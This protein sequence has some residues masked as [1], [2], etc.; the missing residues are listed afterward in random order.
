MYTAW[1]PTEPHCRVQL[2]HYLGPGAHAYGVECVSH[3]S[4]L[5]AILLRKSDRCLADSCLSFRELCPNQVRA[6]V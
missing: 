6:A 1:P 3:C 4:L 2:E 5:I